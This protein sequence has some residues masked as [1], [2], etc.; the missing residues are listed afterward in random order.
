METATPWVSEKRVIDLFLSCGD[1]S[2][3]IDDKDRR[4]DKEII[5][6]ET[7]KRCLTCRVVKCPGKEL[8]KKL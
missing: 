4:T 1:D 8:V 6:S 7:K 3:E 5:K 2:V